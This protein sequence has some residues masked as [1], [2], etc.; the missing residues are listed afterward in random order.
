[1]LD[2]D[3]VAKVGRRKDVESGGAGGLLDSQQLVA[4]PPLLL[5]L[6]AMFFVEVGHRV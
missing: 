4:V 3:H 2:L 5:R 6:L 1:M